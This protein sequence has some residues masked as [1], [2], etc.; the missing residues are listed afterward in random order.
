MAAAAAAATIV[1]APGGAH[2]VRRAACPRQ[3]VS[4]SS[5]SSASAIVS[6]FHGVSVS[7]GG[8]LS[9]S[10]EVSALRALESKGSRR[11]GHR[12]LVV[13]KAGPEQRPII[14]G[15]AADSGCGKST[16]MRRLTSV[17]GGAASPPKGGNP[18]SNTLISDTTTVICLD[19]YHSLD[20]YGRKEKGVTALDPRANNFDLMYEQVKAIKEGKSIEKP[21]YNHVT[22]LLDPAEKIDPPKIFV[23]EGLHPMYDERVRD[24]LDFSIYLDISDD[25]KFAWKIQRDMAERGHSLESIKAS[26]AARKPD[27]DAYIDPQKQ[28]ADVVI[29]VLPTQLIPDDNEGKILRVRMIMKEG[30]KDFEPVYLYDEGSTISWIPCGRKLTCSYPGIKFFY[31]PDTYYGHEVSVLEMDGQFDKLDELIYVES[32]LSNI[33]TKFYGE[34]TQQMLKH[35]DFPGSNNG[36]GLFQTIVGLKIRDVFERIVAREAASL[37]SAKV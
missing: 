28:H 27:F 13:C 1:A 24:L 35:A 23:I 31:G 2:S 8:S 30:V 18:D 5:S 25:V 34:I 16:F 3:R 7:S 21:I 6:S 36:T 37:E 22:G 20:R 33:S 17:F 15:L 14:I 32:H 9:L 26:I 29:Q 4:S 11:R 12:A 10:T 19:D